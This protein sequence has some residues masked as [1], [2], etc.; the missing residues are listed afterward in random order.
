MGDHVMNRIL[1][2]SGLCL[3]ISAAPQPVEY[4]FDRVRS[5][6]I[7]ASAGAEVRAKEGTE[8]RGGDRVRTGWIGYAVLGANRHAATF[9]IFSSSDVLLAAGEP[10]VILTLERGRIKAFFD[11]FAGG[12]PRV[13]KTPGALL[14]VR[15]TRY[16][17]DVRRD[18]NSSLAVFEGA[19]EVISP[20]RPQPLIVRAGE[21]C[22]FGRRRAPAVRPMPRGM[23][24]QSWGRHG[25][26]DSTGGRE[27]T[28]GQKGRGSSSGRRH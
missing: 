7:V 11:K 19:V 25:A 12:E 16:G 21:L 17:V 2:T 1:L 13:V 18:G 5:K 24:E 4:R 3:L 27:P 6:V 15:G 14:A 26:P 10:G 9:E 23:N 28:S 22:E 20:L 8:A